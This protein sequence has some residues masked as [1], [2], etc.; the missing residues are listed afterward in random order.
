MKIFDPLELTSPITI[1]FKMLFQIICTSKF[2]CDDA[3][4][5]EQINL[6]EKLRTLNK[7]VTPRAILK[8]IK[9]NEFLRCEMHG[10]CDSLLKAYSAMLYLKVVTKER[11]FVRFLSAKS[12]VVPYKTLTIPQL[13]M[14]GCHLLSKLVDS[15][16]RAIGI[17]VK[18]DEVYVST[19][20][21]ICL[22]WIKS[23]DKEFKD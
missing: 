22:W 6:L 17:I 10:F 8:D 7:L 23:V 5:K 1:Q 15:A 11:Y 14:L 12:K 3:M 20:S 21:E 9:E 2:N 4:P 13:E 18:V 19:D 16:K